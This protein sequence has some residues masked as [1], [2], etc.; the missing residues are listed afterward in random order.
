M[1]NRLHDRAGQR[2]RRSQ[3][4]DAGVRAG[5][6]TGCGAG[7]RRRRTRQGEAARPAQCRSG[8]ER[9][10]AHDFRTIDQADAG[11]PP[12]RGQVGLDGQRPEERPDQRLLH[13]GRKDH[14]VLRPDRQIETERCRARD[15]HRP[16]DGARAARAQPRSRLAHA[17]RARAGC[18]RADRRRQRGCGGARGHGDAGDLR[19]AAQPRAGVGGRSHRPR[20]DGARRLRPARGAD[21]VAEDGA[22]QPEQHAGVSQHASDRCVAALDAPVTAAA[23]APALPGRGETLYPARVQPRAP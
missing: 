22:G 5:S 14:G 16:R 21:V 12:R 10:C 9:S 6:R 19:P 4:D 17:R 1:R 3:A 15:C 18:D 7:L 8:A 20:A 13:A 23:R 2:R 11:V